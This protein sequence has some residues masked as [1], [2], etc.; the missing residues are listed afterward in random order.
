MTRDV[1]MAGLTPNHRLAGRATISWVSWF[2]GSKAM[3][4]SFYK[5]RITTITCELAKPVVFIVPA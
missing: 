4:V 1:Q 3:F 5:Y 2:S